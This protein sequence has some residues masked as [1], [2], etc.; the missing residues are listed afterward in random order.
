[1]TDPLLRVENLRT[2]FDT[3]NGTVAAV[4]GATFGINPGEVV[5]LVGESGAG[6]SVT[7]QSIIG[8]HAPGQ[9][10]EG[11]ITFDGVDLTDIPDWR[12]RQYRGTRIS[13]VFQDPTT[14]LNPV[15]DVGEQ[16]A[17]AVH[18]H[19]QDQQSLLDYLHTPLISDRTA[20]RRHRKRAI[21][22][23]ESVGIADP[24]DRVDAY[25]HELSGGMRQRVLLAI[26]LAGDP[27]LLIA[28]EPT[29]ALDATTQ[30][31]ILDQ[32]RSIAE[33]TDT[34]VLVI[35]H[36]LGVVADLCDQTVVLYDG[37]VVEQGPTSQLLDA[38][39][40]P[41][42][43][44]LLACARGVGDGTAMSTSATESG[45]GTA[46][47][48]GCRFAPR[49]PYATEACEM[50]DPPVI[51]ISD[52]HTV[53][54]GELDAV[55]ANTTPTG[56]QTTA[57]DSGTTAAGVSTVPPTDCND[58]A[59]LAEQ[60]SGTSPANAEDTSPV[61]EAQ[62]VVKRY[63]VSTSLLDRLFGERRT[64][65]ALSD[66]S[67]S[68]HSGET[69]GIVGESGSGKSTLAR[70]F[71]G[72]EA[73][74]EG[75]IRFDGEAVGT[76]DERKPDQLADVGVVFQ[77]PESSFNPRQQVRAIIAEPLYEQG[78]SRERRDRRVAELLSRVE[79][80]QAVATRRPHQLSGGQ[81]QRVAIARAIALEPRVVIFDEPV[82][83]L[84]VSVQTRLLSLL[85][86]L[87]DRLGLTYVVISHDLDVVQRLAD[88]VAV[89]YLGKIVEQGPADTLFDR[90][91][92]PYTNALVN[93]VPS[94]DGSGGKRLDGPIPS[95]I[96]VPS[97]CSFH[98]R[99]P[100]ATDDCE[101]Q[102]PPATTLGAVESRCHY[103]EEFTAGDDYHSGEQPKTPSGTADRPSNTV[104]PEPT[105]DP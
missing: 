14:T 29:T 55:R 7:A 88:R 58:T 76:V 64:I 30:A 92:H 89:L 41:Y 66:V 46:S 71:A 42:T 100:E 80:P 52:D 22:L 70:L 105:N 57:V 38:P 90:P 91:A 54:C 78:W 104:Q 40:H 20:W 72:L 56:R 75:A 73:P 12:R 81:L 3:P 1:M 37:T 6:K 77:A 103:A 51:P 49:C 48:H 101:Q 4:D 53:A 44:G 94:I 31:R 82:S 69:V 47:T 60:H 86:D 96:D 32:L 95:A 24:A 102:E 16:I 13:M 2:Q 18:T 68:V 63:N 17:E 19:E 93:A 87:Q 61:F 5:G 21:E 50:G 85:S 62:R 9:I 99:C 79:L 39:E 28:D 26:A 11:N 74:T 10:V 15:F 35:T 27:D 33:T 59:T 65:D 67:L 25:P 36:D 43:Q 23:M 34:A 98:P 84:D 8:L 45:T 97:G 83:A